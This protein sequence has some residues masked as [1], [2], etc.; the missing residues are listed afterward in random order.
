MKYL[1][2]FL[3][4]VPSVALAGNCIID[5]DENVVAKIEY[6]PDLKDLDSRNE[7]VVKCDDDIV[8]GDADY[9]NKK[10][11]K[12]VKTKKELDAE[13]E[14]ANQLVEVKAKRKSAKD[15]LKA[16]GLTEDEVQSIVGD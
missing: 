12:R 7:F 15:K 6:V 2:A 13:A 3:I 8:I 4:L 10:V 1:L 11:V 14:Y 5:K 16:L 9:K